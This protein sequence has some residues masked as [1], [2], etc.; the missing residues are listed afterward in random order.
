MGIN[1]FKENTCCNRNNAILLTHT[2]NKDDNNSNP[3]I[4]FTYNKDIKTNN[5]D[6]NSENDENK[7]F[8]DILYK[9]GI[10]NDKE[11]EQKGKKKV[12]II[13]FNIIIIYIM[14]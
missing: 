1:L 6:Y 10:L 5:I 2:V 14:S 11:E 8:N 4:K 9:N 12:N 3:N 13:R 7:K